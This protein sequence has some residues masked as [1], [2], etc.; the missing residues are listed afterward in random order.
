METT[1]DR[2]VAAGAPKLPS[3][4]SY[5]IEQGEYGDLV[6]DVVAA[7]RR[8]RFDLIA[9]RRVDVSSLTPDN[10]EGSVAAAAIDAFAEVRLALARTTATQALVGTH[11]PELSS[12][13]AKLGV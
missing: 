1:Y 7:K 3:S 12:V 5:R 2:L 13:A 9:R 10:V 8:G 4:L 11:G 6:V